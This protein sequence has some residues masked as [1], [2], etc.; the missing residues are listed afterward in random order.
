MHVGFKLSASGEEVGLVDRDGRTIIDAVTFGPQLP[1]VALG[2]LP[3]GGS[4]DLLRA[5]RGEEGTGLGRSRS[6]VSARRAS[7]LHPA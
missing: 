6:R 1:D 5:G 4:Y 7:L 3:D 2:R